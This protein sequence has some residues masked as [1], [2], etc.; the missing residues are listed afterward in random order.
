MKKDS[1]FFILTD[2]EE[3]TQYFTQ[4]LMLARSYDNEVILITPFGPFFEGGPKLKTPDLALLEAI[5]EELWER[6]RIE[7]TDWQIRD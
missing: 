1:F 3:T 2:M 6:I 7:E 4:A 5:S